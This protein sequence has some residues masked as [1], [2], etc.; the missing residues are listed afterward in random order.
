MFHK[1]NHSLSIS[2]PHLYIR[3]ISRLTTTII[4]T[5][6]EDIAVLVV[7]KTTGFFVFLDVL[8]FDVEMSRQIENQN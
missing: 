7:A 4:G 5:F 6:A 1:F 2:L 3:Y 8:N